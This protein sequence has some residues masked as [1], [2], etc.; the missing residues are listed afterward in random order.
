MYAA[1]SGFIRA[2]KRI[3]TTDLLE[4]W[5]LSGPTGEEYRTVC[6]SAGSA[7]PVFDIRLEFIK[8]SLLENEKTGIH[9]RTCRPFR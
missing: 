4:M 8:N 5:I 6:I 3:A 2:L 9:V 1:G 7:I